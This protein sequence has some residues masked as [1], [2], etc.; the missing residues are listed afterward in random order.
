[1]GKKFFW[2]CIPVN[3][4]QITKKMPELKPLN[5]DEYKIQAVKNVQSK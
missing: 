5:E 4:I 1:M 3:Y 2:K